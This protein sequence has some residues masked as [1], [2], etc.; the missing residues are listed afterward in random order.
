MPPT[1]QVFKF[2]FPVTSRQCQKETDTNSDI[3][4]NF[5]REFQNVCIFHQDASTKTTV[6]AGESQKFLLGFVTILQVSLISAG[7]PEHSY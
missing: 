3:A 1:A 5:G 7:R 2:A 4:R 6:I